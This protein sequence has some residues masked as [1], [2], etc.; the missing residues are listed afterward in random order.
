MHAF[1]ACWRSTRSCARSE[2]T[3]A[4]PLRRVLGVLL[5]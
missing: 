3:S 5:A 1:G 2:L 4:R